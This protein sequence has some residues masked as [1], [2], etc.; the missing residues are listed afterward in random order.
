MESM[1]GYIG[2]LARKGMIGFTGKKADFLCKQIGFFYHGSETRF[3]R[4][5]CGTL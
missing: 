5:G 1:G 4:R 3:T 2:N